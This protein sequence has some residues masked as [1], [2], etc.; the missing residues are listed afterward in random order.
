MTERTPFRSELV[1]NDF[2]TDFE[3]TGDIRLLKD[4]P[5]IVV[6]QEQLQP[7]LGESDWLN[8]KEIQRRLEKFNKG[9]GLFTELRETYGVHVPSINFVVGKDGQE[10]KV[11]YTVTD[12]IQGQSLYT[13]ERSD[14]KVSDEQQRK[15][16]TLFSK[17][18]KYLSDKYDTEGEYI[19]GIMGN[20]EYVYGHRAGENEDNL[21]MVDVEPKPKKVI[22]SD[23][24]S[25]NR[26][27]KTMK[28]L[29]V[30]ARELRDNNGFDWSKVKSQMLELVS[31]IEAENP[32][33]AGN[34]YIFGIINDIKET[35]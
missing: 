32:Q 11:I 15:L 17:L 12:R 26:F 34:E 18:T 1:P 2:D 35:E 19:A 30:H 6:R 20:D 7:S 9:K 8:S 24:E 4:N 22:K 13:M 10:N 31:K 33:H 16:E 25:M 21:Y 29:M 5:E 23:Q 27:F 3:K 28:G 14:W